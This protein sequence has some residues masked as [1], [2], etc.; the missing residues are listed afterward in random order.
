MRGEGAGGGGKGKCRPDSFILMSVCV[1]R[2]NV[3]INDNNTLYL[4]IPAS[5]T[6]GFQ[7]NTTASLCF[8]SIFSSRQDSGTEKANN[9][10]EN[11]DRT[12]M[13]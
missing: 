8:E 13:Y 9:K 3:R 1:N 4:V 11:I 10:A 2:V 7:F 5:A 6:G 12:Q